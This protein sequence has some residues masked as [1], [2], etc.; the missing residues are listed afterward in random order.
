MVPPILWP[1]TP[2]M[3]KHSATT[4]CPAKAASPWSNIGITLSLFVSLWKN[5]LALVCPNT[6]GLTA[7]KWEGL[8]VKLTCTEL[9][10]NSL[11]ADA[12]RWYFTSP[13]TPPSAGPGSPANS[14]NIFFKGFCITLVKILSL[15]LW[16]IPILTSFAPSEPPNLIICSIAGIKDSHP[17]NPNLFV[18]TYFVC[19]YFSKPSASNTRFNMAFFPSGVKEISFSFPSILSWTQLFS[20]GSSMCINSTPTLEQ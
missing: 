11:S 14:L 8:A 10:S 3:A 20:S 17:S 5:C 15:P 6:T 19:K 4:P 7:S 2:D 1:G 13:E 12:P 16:G 18:P 9:P